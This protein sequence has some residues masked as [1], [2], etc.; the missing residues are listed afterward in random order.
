MRC[1]PMAFGFRS[2]ARCRWSHGSDGTATRGRRVAQAWRLVRMDR[3][4]PRRRRAYASASGSGAPARSSGSRGTARGGSRFEARRCRPFVAYTGEEK[5]L[6]AR[7][8]GFERR[9][10]RTV[11]GAGKRNHCR[12]GWLDLGHDSFLPIRPAGPQLA[13]CPQES[14]RWLTDGF[15]RRANPRNAIACGFNHTAA[16]PVPFRGAHGRAAPAWLSLR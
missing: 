16:L 4:M 13:L 12:R 11:R 14:L 3:M 2:V 7:L 6:A 8:V 5:D 10:G 15:R 1:R 9:T